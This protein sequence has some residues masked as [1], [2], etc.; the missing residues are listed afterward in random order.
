MPVEGALSPI[1]GVLS[2]RQNERSEIEG[3][4]PQAW[5]VEGATLAPITVCVFS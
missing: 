1:N 2:Q 4:A 5:P 3:E